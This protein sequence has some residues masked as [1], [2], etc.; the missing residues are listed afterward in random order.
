MIES[1]VKPVKRTV[2]SYDVLETEDKKSIPLDEI[3]RSLKQLSEVKYLWLS[4]YSEPF[5]DFIKA[6]PTY[7]SITSET[8]DT[9]PI[10][11]TDLP[12]ALSQPDVTPDQALSMLIS[13]A[14]QAIQY[15][16][17]VLASY[18]TVDAGEKRSRLVNHLYRSL[19]TESILRTKEPHEFYAQ[20]LR[21]IGT[22]NLEDV[23][24]AI[25]DI[26]KPHILAELAS[27]TDP[28]YLER[29]KLALV[30]IYGNETVAL[31]YTNKDKTEKR[32]SPEEI[33]S[34]RE[35]IKDLF[36]N[37][38]ANMHCRSTAQ[39]IESITWPIA[40][41]QAF[42]KIML[43]LL[44]PDRAHEATAEADSKPKSVDDKTLNEVFK[45]LFQLN[46]IE[47]F[48]LAD[49]PI[50]PMKVLTLPPRTRTLSHDEMECFSRLLTPAINALNTELTGSDVTN[51]EAF[52]SISALL[53]AEIKYYNDLIASY[54]TVDTDETRTRLEIYVSPVYTT[55]VIQ[56]LD[57]EAA[58]AFYAEFMKI[59]GTVNLV[60]VNLALSDIVLPHVLW[61]LAKIKDAT[62][63]EMH[64]QELIDNY[65]EETYSLLVKNKDKATNRCTSDEVTAMNTKIKALLLKSN[66]N[67]LT[68]EP[69]AIIHSASEAGIKVFEIKKQIAVLLNQEAAHVA[70]INGEIDKKPSASVAH[71]DSAAAATTSTTNTTALL[72]TSETATTLTASSDK[73]AS[74]LAMNGTAASSTT[75]TPKIVYDKLPSSTTPAEKKKFDP[76]KEFERLEKVSPATPATAATRPRANSDP[77]TNRGS[78]LIDGGVLLKRD[79]PGS[80]TSTGRSL[81]DKTQSSIDDANSLQDLTSIASEISIELATKGRTLVT[82]MSV[83]MVKRA[84]LLKAKADPV[85][86][87]EL[88]LRDKNIIRETLKYQRATFFFKRNPLGTTSI[89]QFDDICK[90]ADKEKAKAMRMKK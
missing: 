36:I 52:T 3:L 54:N 72:P 23:K 41:L 21:I 69:S 20:F 34:L 31:L 40:A 70:T 39:L 10:D 1:D 2:V 87:T 63:L 28:A 83:A 76:K 62:Y 5:E 42:K 33:A 89:R 11:L 49:Y 68:V 29:N 9:I 16:N 85:S 58:Q 84:I 48:V 12:I 56:N 71:S 90:K 53:D 81:I 24:L 77:I 61:E 47:H 14:D 22:I 15:F 6:L 7:E 30:S 19:T 57:E 88:N 73:P 55:E 27:Y 43:P 79:A 82:L 13:A 4:K 65:G 66:Q 59:I 80:A 37:S 46:K 51:E 50:P 25:A 74:A 64:K 60:D 8:L 86:T 67:I 35:Q 32:C 38:N 75:T 18:N 26:A 44:A 17:D 45:L 78:V